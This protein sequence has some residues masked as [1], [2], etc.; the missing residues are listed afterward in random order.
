MIVRFFT[1][2]SEQVPS[3]TRNLNDFIRS[4]STSIE[5]LVITFID[6]FGGTAELEFSEVLDA[7]EYNTE[8]WPESYTGGYP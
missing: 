7:G 2:L 8:S 3:F 5:L 1:N 6:I 4:A